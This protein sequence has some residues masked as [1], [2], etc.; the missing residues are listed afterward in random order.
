PRPPL[1]PSTTLFR[2]AGLEPLQG[3]P[4]VG[5]PVQALHRVA[6]RLEHPLHLVRATFVDGQLDPA[7]AEAAD[8]RGR[9][10]AVLELDTLLER[11]QDRKST[12]LNSSHQI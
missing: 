2:S 1:F 6:D 8:L 10:R 3:Q 11:A 5:A 9:G 4:G 7:G 12:R